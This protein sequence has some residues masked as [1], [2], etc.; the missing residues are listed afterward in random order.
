MLLLMNSLASDVVIRTTV[1]PVAPR[2]FGLILAPWTPALLGVG[3]GHTVRLG[4]L[5]KTPSMCR[6]MIINSYI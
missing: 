2:L 5:L 4:R 6:R 1:G 3:I